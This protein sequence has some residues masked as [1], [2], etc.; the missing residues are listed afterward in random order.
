[1]VFAIHSNTRQQ[2]FKILA[3]RNG[4]EQNEMN[5]HRKSISKSLSE[6]F[7][8]ENAINQVLLKRK[9]AINIKNN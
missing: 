9:V 3:G 4:F 5:R 7:F 8:F 1:M 2:N 6:S